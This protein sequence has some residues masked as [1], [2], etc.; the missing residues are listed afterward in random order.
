MQGIFKKENVT[1]GDIRGHKGHHGVQ[2]TR[3]SLCIVYIQ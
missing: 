2:T 1:G 3:P